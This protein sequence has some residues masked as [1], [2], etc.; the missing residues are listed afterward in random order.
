MNDTLNTQKNAMNTGRDS[1]GFNETPLQA[2]LNTVSDI[3]VLKM[4]T[5]YGNLHT[6]T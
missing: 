3:D 4:Q 6:D 2:L 5:K 1:A